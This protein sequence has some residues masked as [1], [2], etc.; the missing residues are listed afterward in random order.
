MRIW[1]HYAVID[2]KDVEF[3]R[4]LISKSIFAPSGEGDLRWK[5]CQFIKN[6]YDLWVPNLE[7]LC[8]IIAMLLADLN[9]DL[10]EQDLVSS[11]SGLSQNLED[12]NFADEGM[13]PDSQPTAQPIT[14]KN[15]IGAGSSSYRKKMT[16]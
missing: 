4:H 2:G 15:T 14:P 5:A 12:Y 10:S 8:S 1:G 3:Y 11:R 9:F 16:R 7:K 13:M 6:I